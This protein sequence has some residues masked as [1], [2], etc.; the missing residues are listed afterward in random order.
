[1]NIKG[2]GTVKAHRVAYELANG[3]I[4]KGDGPHGTVVMHSCDNPLCCNPAHLSIGTQA[5]NLRDMAE[6]GRR[7]GEKS[8]HAKLTEEQALYIKHSSRSA[9]SIALELGVSPEAAQMIRRGERWGH[10]R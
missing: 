4:P 6:K 3:P 9:R 5:D 1:M 7:K 10:L 8:P 2:R